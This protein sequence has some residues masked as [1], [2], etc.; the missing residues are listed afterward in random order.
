MADIT[1]TR[2]DD[3]EHLL[4]RFQVTVTEGRGSTHHDVT[5]SSADFERLGA[6]HRSPEDFVRACFEFLLERESKESI[7]SSFDIS[8]IGRYFPEFERVIAAR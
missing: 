6:S 8:V 3:V 5:L 2:G 1:V 4:S 7:L